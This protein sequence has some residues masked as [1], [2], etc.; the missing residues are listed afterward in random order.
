MMPPPRNRIT[1]VWMTTGILGSLAALVFWQR[2]RGN[3]PIMDQRGGF[4]G[5]MIALGLTGTGLLMLGGCALAQLFPSFSST[6]WR[7]W[8]RTETIAA[9]LNLFPW[10]IFV[11][12]IERCGDLYNQVERTG[13]PRRPRWR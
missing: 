2:I 7:R 10:F 8:T 9:L 13:E 1:L 4:M 3:A 11:V 5:L 6:L 12:H